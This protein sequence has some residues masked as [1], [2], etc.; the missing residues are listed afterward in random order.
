MAG[1]LEPAHNLIGKIFQIQEEDLLAYV[2]PSLC[3]SS[4]QEL[5]GAKR[6]ALMKVDAHAG[7]GKLSIV[8]LRRGVAAIPTHTLQCS[9]PCA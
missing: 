1:P 6:E 5:K 2:E 7:S 3:L 4:E 9:P 8:F